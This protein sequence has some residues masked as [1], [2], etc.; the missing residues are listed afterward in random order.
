[1]KNQT[2]KTPHSSTGLGFAAVG[3]LSANPPPKLKLKQTN[4]TGLR[5]RSTSKYPSKLTQLGYGHV[6]THLLSKLKQ[7]QLN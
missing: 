7:N 6:H 2:N 3:L 1:M 5:T 4:S